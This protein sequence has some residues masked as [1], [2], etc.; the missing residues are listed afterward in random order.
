[1]IIE[2]CVMSHAKNNN[3]NNKKIKTIYNLLMEE[4]LEK[5]L[6]TAIMC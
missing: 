4:I 6:S 2:P 3:N 1:M 5:D